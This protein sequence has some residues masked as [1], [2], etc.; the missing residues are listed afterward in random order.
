MPQ[1][2]TC[3]GQPAFNSG[4]DA[5]AAASPGRSIEAFEPY[6]YV[7]VPSGS[8]AGMIRAHYPELLAD[9]PAWRAARGGAR[10]EDLRDHELPCR[11]H[12]ATCPRGARSTP[13]ATYHDSCSGL[14]ELGVLASRAR[15]S[16][17]SRGSRCGKLE[18]NDVCC[19]FGGTFC[20]KYP[21]HLQRHRRGEGGGDRAHRR[22][23][24][25][26]A[27]ISAA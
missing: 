15:C 12:A 10:R 17:R 1:A 14:R 20:V 19:G 9:D 3:C 27:A 8:C 26:G 4:D 13:S 5:D 25:A 16:P 23:P 11:R 7:V 22:R 21:G 24:P 2:Q 6:D 18:G